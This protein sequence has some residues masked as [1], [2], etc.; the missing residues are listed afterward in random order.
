MGVSEGD[1]NVNEFDANYAPRPRSISPQPLP[2]D[3]VISGHS[4][5]SID[6]SIPSPPRNH[7]HP[8]HRPGASRPRTR[9]VRGARRRRCIEG[10]GGRAGRR[11]FWRFRIGGNDLQSNRRGRQWWGE[12]EEKRADFTGLESFDLRPLEPTVP[13][14]RSF[15]KG[16]V[17][18]LTSGPSLPNLPLSPILIQQILPNALTLSSGTQSKSASLNGLF[19]ILEPCW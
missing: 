18:K 17:H 6:P 12:G 5:R 2:W 11:E 9:Q 19:P 14:Q 10:V 1:D 13:Q 8:S 3:Y 7:T 4:Q 15:F 16:A